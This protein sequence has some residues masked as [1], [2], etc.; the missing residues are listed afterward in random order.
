MKSNIIFK[1]RFLSLQLAGTRAW[2]KF[3]LKTNIL[4]QWGSRGRNAGLQ[5]FGGKLKFTVM[6]TVY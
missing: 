4:V 6:L 1:Q 2:V 3:K 5:N